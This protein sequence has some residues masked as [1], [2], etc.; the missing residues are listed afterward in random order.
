MSEQEKK[1]I[2]ADDSSSDEDNVQ[3]VEEE[4]KTVSAFPSADFLMSRKQVILDAIKQSGQSLEFMESVEKAI[5]RGAWVRKHFDKHGYIKARFCPFKFRI[6]GD[7][8]QIVEFKIISVANNLSTV[9]VEYEYLVEEPDSDDEN[10]MTKKTKSEFFHLQQPKVCKELLVRFLEDMEIRFDKTKKIAQILKKPDQKKFSIY[11]SIEVCVYEYDF[12]DKSLEEIESKMKWVPASMVFPEDC[13]TLCNNKTTGKKEYRIPYDPDDPYNPLP[14]LEKLDPN[15]GKKAKRKRKSSPK[16]K[17]STTTSTTN[18]NNNNDPDAEEQQ[19]Q[20]DEE[21]VSIKKAKKRMKTS[22]AA[23]SNS[24][25]YL[26][27]IA[28]QNEILREQNEILKANTKIF[29]DILVR[30]TKIFGKFT[31]VFEN[32]MNPEET[33][34]ETEKENNEKPESTVNTNTN[35]EENPTKVEQQPDNQSSDTKQ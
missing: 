14:M 26:N 12:A 22:G 2:V 31:F 28:D 19:D 35:P 18:E 4:E 24:P 10:T 5:I 6:S 32:W 9:L 15:F 34:D 7:E 8:N 29:K 30:Q 11:D 16:K 1:I 21:Q 13:R 17:S 20:D 3:E 23:T 27:L 25:E 33:K